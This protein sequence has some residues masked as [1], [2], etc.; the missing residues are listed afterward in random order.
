MH[1]I[2]YKSTIPMYFHI[3]DEANQ[4]YV[5]FSFEM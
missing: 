2:T 4:Q 3:V 5:I 1:T